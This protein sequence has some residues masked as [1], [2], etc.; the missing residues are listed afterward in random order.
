MTAAAWAWVGVVVLLAGYVLGFDLWAQ[1]TGHTTMSGQFHDWMQSQLTGPI[2]V[3]A[4]AAVSAG[5]VYHFL[6]NK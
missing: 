6:I 4:W 2:V 1:A 3:A 5:L